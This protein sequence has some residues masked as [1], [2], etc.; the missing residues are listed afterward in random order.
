MDD[1][2]TQLTCTNCQQITTDEGK[3]VW[4][5]ENCGTENI[6]PA[7][8]KTSAPTMPVSSQADISASPDSL[9]ADSIAAAAQADISA[10]SAQAGAPL[11]DI[12]PAVSK[13]AASEENSLPVTQPDQTGS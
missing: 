4:V 2:Q 10:A 6:Q 7:I 5:C 12:P 3:P 8:A 9:A 11:G 13:P 1:T